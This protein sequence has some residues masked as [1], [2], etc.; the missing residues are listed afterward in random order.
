MRR[1]LDVLT[2]FFQTNGTR[3]KVRRFVTKLVLFRLW[4][5]FQSAPT[6]W[7]A[8][9]EKKAQVNTG[10]CSNVY[11]KIVVCDVP[12]A[13]EILPSI[14]MGVALMTL[15]LGL[16]A[17]SLVLVLASSVALG[18]VSLLCINMPQQQQ[19]RESPRWQPPLDTEKKVMSEEWVIQ[20]FLVIK[21]YISQVS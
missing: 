16:L 19:Q 17:S 14:R 1:T 8:R 12:V 4:I 21:E 11:Q 7:F 10:C 15:S 18:R 13:L 2:R 20:Y 5:T 3:L 6:I 9:L